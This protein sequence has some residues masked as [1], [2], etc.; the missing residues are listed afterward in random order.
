MTNNACLVKHIYT[1]AP[2][3]PKPRD[4]TQTLRN[5]RA[6]LLYGTDFFSGPDAKAPLNLLKMAS[7]SPYLYQHYPGKK[8]QLFI[9]NLSLSATSQHH[10]NYCKC[11]Y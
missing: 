8:L 3:K 1:K 6:A 2:A 9:C 7:K 4:T 5:E 11:P 10:I